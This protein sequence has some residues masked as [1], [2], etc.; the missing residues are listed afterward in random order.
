VRPKFSPELILRYPFRF[1]VT[2]TWN[3]PSASR[4][5]LAIRR[6]SVPRCDYPPSRSGSRFDHDDSAPLHSDI[7]ARNAPSGPDEELGHL[8]TM[9]V[10]MHRVPSCCGRFVIRLASCLHLGRFRQSRQ[11]GPAQSP[12]ARPPR[13]AS[14]IPLG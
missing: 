4:F 11:R 5:Y 1:L 12:I 7:G 14:S 8:E 3:V 6:A 10:A 13:R 2:E 9:S